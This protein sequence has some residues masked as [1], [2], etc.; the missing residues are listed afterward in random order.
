MGCCTRV[1]EIPTE[2]TKYGGCCVSLQERL[3]CVGRLDEGGRRHQAEGEKSQGQSLF[4]CLPLHL[5]RTTPGQILISSV[6]LWKG[7]SPLGFGGITSE[8]NILIFSKV[9]VTVQFT[10]DRGRQQ[11][12]CLKYDT[13]GECRLQNSPLL[14][15]WAVNC[16]HNE[17]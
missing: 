15:F 2:H 1:C 3:G 9:I 6:L 17:C 13:A 8:E 14:Q 10:L 11:W 4:P 7:S 12:W 5:S 16:D